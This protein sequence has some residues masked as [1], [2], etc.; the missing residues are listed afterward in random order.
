MKVAS[1]S[2]RLFV[3]ASIVGCSSWLALAADKTDVGRGPTYRAKDLMGMAVR[4]PAD[5]SLGKIEDV[6]ID[7]DTGHIRYA[8]LSFGGFLGVSDKY[9]AVPWKALHIVADKNGKGH[10]VQLSVD[11]E[12]LKNAPG[13]QKDHWPDYAN[14]SWSTSVDEFYKPRT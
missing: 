9:F 5:E 13:F 10:H 7:L 11:K 2:R 14:P 8:V 12:R 4:N 1:F 3:V 6:V